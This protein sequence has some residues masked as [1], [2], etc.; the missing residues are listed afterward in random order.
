[1][2]SSGSFIQLRR[3]SMLSVYLILG[4]SILTLKTLSWNHWI[5][6][7]LTKAQSFNVMGTGEPSRGKIHSWGQMSSLSM[8]NQLINMGL[9]TLDMRLRGW[10]NNSKNTNIIIQTQ[11]S[12]VADWASAKLTINFLGD[13]HPRKVKEIFFIKKS[14]TSLMGKWIRIHLPMQGTW[15]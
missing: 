7:I 14:Q 9:W 1:M 10:F 13:N 8:A 12:Q 2:L 4:R 6:R 15:V 11:S 3:Q 5:T